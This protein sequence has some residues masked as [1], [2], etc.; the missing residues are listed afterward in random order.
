MAGLNVRYAAALFELEKES[1]TIDESLEQAVFLRDTLKDPDCRRVVSHPH[2]SAAEKMEFFRSAFASSI[3]ENLLGMLYLAIEKDRENY[4]VPALSS[5][6][7]MVHRYKRRT[8]AQVTSAGPLNGEQVSALQKLLSAKLDKQVD[9]AVKV[10]P[11]LIGGVSI[12]VDGYL[13]DRTLKKKLN[14]LKLNL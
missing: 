6:I 2:I 7:G 14:D 11:E 10:D 9:V 3:S 13:I 8:T 5:Y 4:L 12:Y 1:G